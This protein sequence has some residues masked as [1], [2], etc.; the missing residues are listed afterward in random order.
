MRASE[1]TLELI[2]SLQKEQ[3]QAANII[4]DLTYDPRLSSKEL[5]QELERSKL[6]RG[7]LSYTEEN[8][9]I[10]GVSR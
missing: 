7:S 9:L 3:L 5:W 8:L 10:S 1:L 4:S 6:R 2:A